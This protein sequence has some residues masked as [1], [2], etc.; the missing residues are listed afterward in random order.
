[1]FNSAALQAN[2]GM[3]NF[4][5][6]SSRM[7]APV[8]ARA[9]LAAPSSASAGLNLEQLRSEAGII[10]S[11]IDQ[12]I[13]GVTGFSILQEWIAKPLAGDWDA[14]ARGANAWENAGKAVGGVAENMIALP[15][16]IGSAWVGEAAAAFSASQVKVA[17]ALT[18]F[19]P[20]S[21]GMK[22]WC[23]ALTEMSVYIAK[24][25]M[26]AIKELSYKVAGMLSAAA[27]VIGAVS[28]PAWVASIA[29]SVTTWTKRIRQGIEMFTKFVKMVQKIVDA[30][31]RAVQ[32]I[33]LLLN[34]AQ[35]A[36]HAVGAGDSFLAKGLGG[37]QSFYGDVGKTADSIKN[38][39]DNS[40][41][42]AEGVGNVAGVTLPGVKL[43]TVKTSLTDAAARLAA[44]KPTETRS[45]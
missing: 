11:T 30:V 22:A 29:Q 27:T 7:S 17:G 43:P 45:S 31:R 41:K 35:S 10:V 32:A 19:Q 28:V 5:K 36:L 23:T 4:Q 39:N 42:T 38:A 8:D 26:S 37:A 1:M 13:E 9:F 21:I 25:I 12:A 6:S 18:I 15:R 40:I 33:Q 44:D 24:M 16:Q 34:T 14:F 2:V 20:L 3:L